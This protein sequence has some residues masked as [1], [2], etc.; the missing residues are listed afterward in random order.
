MSC[1][2]TKAR[3]YTFAI[4]SPPAPRG[5]SRGTKAEEGVRSKLGRKS[6]EVRAEVFSV[7]LSWQSRCEHLRL[8]G[9]LLFIPN[10][11]MPRDPKDRK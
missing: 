1:E 3:F 6:P 5:P 4:L 11:R 8:N 2:R 7:L 9:L 10:E